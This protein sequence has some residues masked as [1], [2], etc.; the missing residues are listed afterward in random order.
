MR[1]LAEIV[2]ALI[3]LVVLSAAY[4]RDTTPSGFDASTARTVSY[5]YPLPHEIGLE[6]PG[7]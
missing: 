1:H 4:I 3:A 5:P 7:R 6:L 2:L